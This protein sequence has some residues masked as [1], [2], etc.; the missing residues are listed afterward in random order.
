MV[1]AACVRDPYNDQ[2]RREARETA[3]QRYLAS[4][5][6]PDR[7]ATRANMCRREAVDR[8]RV[9]A[10]MGRVRKSMH[11]AFTRGAPDPDARDEAEANQMELQSDMLGCDT[12]ESGCYGYCANLARRLATPPT[13]PPMVEAGEGQSPP[14]KLSTGEP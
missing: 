8:A 1:V 10:S 4:L 9:V 3:K 2:L 6:C 7:C 12:W 5:P 14:S 11:H 13:A